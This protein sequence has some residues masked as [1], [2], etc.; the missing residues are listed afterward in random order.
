MLSAGSA[1]TAPPPGGNNNGGARKRSSGERRGGSAEQQQQ[2]Y[3]S[4]RI[5]PNSFLTMDG[6]FVQ[7]K[8]PFS[9]PMMTDT[10]IPS[11][12]VGAAV[13]AA[14]AALAPAIP[15]QFYNSL[16]NNNNTDGSGAPPNHQANKGDD[17]VNIK[18]PPSFLPPRH[19]HSTSN[20]HHHQHRL[21]PKQGT[22]VTLAATDLQAFTLGDSESGFLDPASKFTGSPIPEHNHYLAPATRVMQASGRVP[23]PPY[24]YYNNNNSSATAGAVTLHHNDDTATHGSLRKVRRINRT[25]DVVAATGH[26]LSRLTTNDSGAAAAASLS[27]DTT[28]RMGGNNN[29]NEDPFDDDDISPT[30]VSNF[31]SFAAKTP[32]PKKAPPPTPIKQRP[33]QQP[34][35]RRH[36]HNY[37]TRTTPGPPVLT[38]K[39][40]VRTPH[41]GSYMNHMHNAPHHPHHDNEEDNDENPNTLYHRQIALLQ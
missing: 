36:N 29:N 22:P 32:A 14:Q 31:P 37:N 7:S 40:A 9:S 38:R 18:M 28:M 6:R 17:D 10:P 34:Y 5:S 20:L 4:P 13:G 25:D 12:S 21:Q 33:S 26:H 15:T 19:K 24:C 30:D 27:I 2:Q 35:G 11:D 41:P 3:M 39:G 23:P 8:N 16:S 1:S